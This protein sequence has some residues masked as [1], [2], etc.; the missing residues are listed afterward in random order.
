MSFLKRQVQNFEDTFIHF[1][2]F[3]MK[4]VSFLYSVQKKFFQKMT[5][6]KMS[7]FRFYKKDMK[8]VAEKITVIDMVSFFNI[9]NKKMIFTFFPKKTKKVSEF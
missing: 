7:V 4:N 3:S 2:I 6:I 5:K 1:S 9:F 8:I